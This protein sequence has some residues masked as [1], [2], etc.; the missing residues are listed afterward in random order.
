MHI[1]ICNQALIFFEI[2]NSF[3]RRKIITP[4]CPLYNIE[5]EVST[6]SEAGGEGG[7]SCSEPSYM[8]LY[9][10]IPYLHQ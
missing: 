9:I 8:Y 2:V 1:V 7:S 3:L 4:Y 5:Y 10:A 6:V